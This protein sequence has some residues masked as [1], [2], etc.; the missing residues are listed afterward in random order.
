MQTAI[1]QSKHITQKC[2]IRYQALARYVNFFQNTAGTAS[3]VN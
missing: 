2:D 3:G 1:A